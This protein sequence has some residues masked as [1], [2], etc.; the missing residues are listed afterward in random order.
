MSYYDAEAAN[1]TFRPNI[2]NQGGGGGGP[3]PLHIRSQHILQERQQK[4]H[5]IQQ[6]LDAKDKEIATYKPK[7]NQTPMTTT[8]IK[9]QQQQPQLTT[10]DE[11]FHQHVTGLEGVLDKTGLRKV[12][13]YMGVFSKVSG[14]GAEEVRE[15]LLEKFWT[16]MGGGG[17]MN[18]G[19]IGIEDFRR[20]MEA[21]LMKQQQQQQQSSTSR[22]GS[23]VSTQ[24]LSS[25]SAPRRSVSTTI[26][27][28][29]PRPS[30]TPPEPLMSVVKKNVM[31]VPLAVADPNVQQQKPNTPIPT[32]SF[33]TMKQKNLTSMSVTPRPVEK[34]Q[35]KQQ[36]NNNKI[37]PPRSRKPSSSPS[38]SQSRGRSSTPIR[39]GGIGQ[40]TPR[41][42]KPTTPSKK[43]TTTKKN[44]TTP[45]QRTRSTTPQRR[46]ESRGRT[47]TPTK[48]NKSNKKKE[49]VKSWVEQELEQCTFRPAV[50]PTTSSSKP[51]LT[52][53]IMKHPPKPSAVQEY[54]QCTFRPN[55][56][57]FHQP[58][59][60][61][62]IAP[63][64][65]PPGFD[66]TV[67]RIRDSR[68]HAQP[69]FEE[70]LRGGS[71][72]TNP[73]TQLPTGS[74]SP[75]GAPT[76]AIPFKFSLEERRKHQQQLMEQQQQ[77]QQA[78]HHQSR[79]RN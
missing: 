39:C 15:G 56:V 11:V 58:N 51:G 32:S 31:K 68:L 70:S 12:L 6:Q 10:I 40:P 13:W 65:T 22:S 21:V 30:Q 48:H 63:P 33:E 50:N 74:S 24:G 54:E 49:P 2:N 41:K 75:P 76:V 78:H 64:P 77:Q 36:L 38:P 43:Q 47:T 3:P 46:S 16:L 53:G 1:C 17:G 37:H 9:Q 8:T 44:S 35:Q 5:R 60:A 72:T 18:G 71:T 28:E 62:P 59:V 34:Q 14:S 67:K 7:I 73:I 52:T 79:Q 26:Q 29:T 61:A 19:G 69:K 20:V 57:S 25:V 42:Q 66:E 27:E 23:F 4:V 45:Q 55:T